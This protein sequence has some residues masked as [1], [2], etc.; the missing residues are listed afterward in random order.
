MNRGIAKNLLKAVVILPFLLFSGCA[1][2]PDFEK[3]VVET[4]GQYRFENM[5][6]E[7]QVNLEW[8]K[9][10]D[11]PVLY[12]FVTMALENNKD[13]QIAAARVE[14]ARAS[15]GFTRAD[16]FP[17]VNIQGGAATGNFGGG[18]RSEDRTTSYYISP[19]LNWELDFWGKFRRA[20]EAARAQL[21]ASEYALKTI[22]ISLISEVVGT[23]YLLLDY[24]LR[25]EISKSTLKS[26]EDS[27]TIIQKRFDRGIIPE[28][29]VNQAQIQKEIAASAVPLYERSV[30]RTENA[31]S[32]LLGKLPGSIKT[33]NGLTNQVVP[34]VI[35]VDLP[36]TLLER[37]PDITEAMYRLQ[38]QTANIGVAEAYRLPAITLTGLFGLASTQLSTFTSEGGIWSVQGGLFGPI[39]DFYKNIRRVQIEEAKTKQALSFYENTVL[40][41][42]REVEDALVDIQTYKIQIASVSNKVAAAKNANRLANLRYDKGVSSYLEVLETERSLFSAELELSELRQ[43]YL[44]G[45]VGLYKAL[46][47]GWTSKE[48]MEKEQSAAASKPVSAK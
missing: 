11:D 8:W 23:Y 4:P 22:Q 19:M 32:I 41:A 21:L 3:P 30:A 38:A 15:L 9:L 47:G 6:V 12:L 34:P 35:P 24:H 40:T 43:Q 1:V 18:S 44:N 42:F 14:E 27:L 48:E 37:R 10:F 36:S 31:L 7:A 46:G 16:Q 13:L 2:G 17:Q 26:R 45:Y 5:P 33:G 39:F 25:L 20:T 28:L 29:D